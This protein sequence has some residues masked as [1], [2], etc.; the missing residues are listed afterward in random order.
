[1]I[2]A[3]RQPAQRPHPTQT[4]TSHTNLVNLTS[5]LRLRSGNLVLIEAIVASG[6]QHTVV[7][8]VAEVP[9]PYW[10]AASPDIT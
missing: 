6:G 4:R 8:H 2:V 5:M 3:L 7:G 9:L 1:M 10:P